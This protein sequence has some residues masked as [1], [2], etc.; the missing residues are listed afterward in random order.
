[1][2]DEPP[3]DGAPTEPAEETPAD[4]APADGEEAKPE[5]AEGGADNDGIA[6]GGT[7]PIKIPEMKPPPDTGVRDR[8]RKDPHDM[9]GL[10]FI[11][12]FPQRMDITLIPKMSEARM[13]WSQGLRKVEQA[14]QE[15]IS[16]M[17]MEFE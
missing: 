8:I 10:N 2:G 3:A 12:E 11:C 15:A 5:G 13:V 14:F 7:A 16:N 4:A 1:M 6:G 17:H 9:H